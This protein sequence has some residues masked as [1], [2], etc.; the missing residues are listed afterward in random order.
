[1]AKLDFCCPNG[2][3]QLD[4]MV[5]YGERP[6]CQDC[7]ATMEI[8]WAS[9][10][11]NVIPDTFGTPLVVEHFGDQPETFTSRS[12]HRRRTKELGLRVRDEHCSA[13]GTDKNR[14]VSRWV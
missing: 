8:L 14:N 12:E 6:P 3:E 13:P 2:H 11:P 10:F 7:G 5:R 1:M 4:M 9:S